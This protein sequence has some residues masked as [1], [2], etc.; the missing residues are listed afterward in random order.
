MKTAYQLDRT[1][2]L[3]HTSMLRQMIRARRYVNEGFRALKDA[4][5]HMAAARRAR[6]LGVEP[7]PQEA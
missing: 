5:R 7:Y 3:A 6:D 1:V 4:Q 2:W